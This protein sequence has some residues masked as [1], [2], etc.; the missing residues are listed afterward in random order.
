MREMAKRDEK[1]S[2]ETVSRWFLGEAK[3]RLLKS[4][5]IAQILGVDPVWL[6][7][8]QQGD[9]QPRERKLRNAE[10][11]GAVNVIAG[12]V[13]MDGG[14]PAFPEEGD[15][16]AKRDSVDL[17]AIIR[18]ANYAFHVSVARTQDDGSLQF[19]VPNE[20]DSAVVLG[21]IRNGFAVRVIELSS[22]LIEQYGT[23]TGGSIK[24]LLD[25][26]TV[27]AHELKSFA[28]RL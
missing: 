8:G 10:I 3:P 16:R 26:D 23:R 4:D 24:L 19:T 1:V 22:E 18:G 20:H 2:R 14:H 12:F 11:D 9:M 15:R 13:Q 28:N 25:E 21:V 6:Y 27:A 5:K 7:L 17:Y